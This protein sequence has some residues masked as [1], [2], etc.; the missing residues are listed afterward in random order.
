MTNR[1]NVIKQI[2]DN[3]PE[4]GALKKAVLEEARSKGYVE[5]LEGHRVYIAHINSPNSTIRAKAE[6]T[7]FDGLFQGTGSGDITKIATINAQDELDKLFPDIFNPQAKLLLQ[8][9]DE[10]LIESDEATLKSIAPVIE[11]SF[12]N[13]VSGLSVP[14]TAESHI[15]KSWGDVH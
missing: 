15:G 9:H 5:T 14:L 6:R 4:I 1:F 2:R 13:S 12:V 10:M 3:I 8:A 11:S 7:A